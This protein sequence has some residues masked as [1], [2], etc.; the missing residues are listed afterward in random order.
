M[1]HPI[2]KDYYVN[3]GSSDSMDY[4]IYANSVLIYSG[5]A[6]KRPG[7]ADIQI[8][9]NDICSDY[10]KNTI[11]NFEPQTF[12]EAAEKVV[13][14]VVADG[15]TEEVEFYN[16]WSYDYTFNPENGLSHTINGR[17]DSRQW[18]IYSAYDASSFVAEITL[19]DGNKT[20]VIIPVEISPSFN[21]DFNSD[22]AKVVRPAQT[23]TA[24]FRLDMF[25][26]IKSVKI[27]STTYQVA[28]SCNRYVLYYSNAYGGWD[29][30][31]IEGNHLMSDNVT[32]M[33]RSLEY[34]NRNVSNRGR[35]NYG[36]E[37]EKKLTLHTSWMSDDQSQRMHHLL[38]S[39]EVFLY[40]IETDEMI[41]ALINNTTTEY[42]TYKSNGGRFVNYTIDL[43]LANIR[44]RV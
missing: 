39:T 26:G 1:A 3:I 30:L 34:D 42:K 38:N 29:S 19:A 40:D 11:P 36:N 17:I 37:I 35:Q 15:K 43:S 31:L 27:G 23:G 2:W 41:P 28:P 8:R 22:F 4:Q 25:T 24:V 20:E 44:Q 18:L 7:A 14:Q 32:R 9:I 21:A 33:T 6:Y 5:K 10:L 12:S 16:D 13:F